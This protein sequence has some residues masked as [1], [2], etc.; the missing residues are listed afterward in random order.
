MLQFH[1]SLGNK[2]E[3]I[4]RCLCTLE[5]ED[6]YEAKTVKSFLH[7]YDFQTIKQVRRTSPFLVDFFN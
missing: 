5:N 4:A 3:K 2:E 7:K 1:T 6:A